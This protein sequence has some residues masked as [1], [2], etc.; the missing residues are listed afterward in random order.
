M[1]VVSL[2]HTAGELKPQESPPTQAHATESP[3]TPLPYRHEEEK[4]FDDVTR[5]AAYLNPEVSVTEKLT[6]Q[7]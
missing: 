6:P 5:A 1:K 3:A 7:G 2:N 4:T